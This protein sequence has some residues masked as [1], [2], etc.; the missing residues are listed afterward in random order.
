M[1]LLQALWEHMGQIAQMVGAI[2][3]ALN[4]IRTKIIDNR[5]QRQHEEIKQIEEIAR[6]L[7][8]KV[9]SD[10]AEAALRYEDD[11]EQSG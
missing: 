1:R 7:A 8:A 2:F 5:V 9:L 4:Y 10:K 6:K 11:P 3:L